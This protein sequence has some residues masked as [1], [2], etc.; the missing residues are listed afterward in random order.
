MIIHEITVIGGGVSGLSFAHYTAINGHRVKVFEKEKGGGCIHSHFLDQYPVDFGAH[1]LTN[2]YATVLDIL[3]YYKATDQIDKPLPLSFEGYAEH[4]FFNLFGRIYWL[5]LLHSVLGAYQIK[6]KGESVRSYYSKIF[7]IKNYTHFFHYVFQA[8]L[9]QNPDDYPAEQLFKKRKRNGKYPKSF[10]LK[11]GLAQLLDLI[12]ANPSIDLEYK[13]ITRVTK[14]QN[15]YV[16]WSGAEKVAVS[17]VLC[18]ACDPKSAALL[19]AEHE[20]V[21]SNLLSRFPVVGIQS[22][23]IGSHK[24]NLPAWNKRN[25]SLIG[26]DM[27]FYAAI[28][29]RMEGVRF[30]LFHF[31]ESTTSDAEKCKLIS[32]LFSVREEEIYVAATRTALLPA[33]SVASM[34]LQDKINL[35]LEGS[36]LYVAGNYMNGLSVEDCCSKARQEAERFNGA[37]GSGTLAL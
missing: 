18:L 3:E 4:R 8:I 24:N 30:W 2:R 5:E 31:K 12:R 15:L 33:V 16:L 35:E 26:F 22:L 23:L 7:G 17:K 27:P 21:L 14:E 29:Y 37:V 13:N 19:M 28:L 11:A 6:K 10:S 20:P 36:R 25:K 32:G 34:E 1:T 9:C